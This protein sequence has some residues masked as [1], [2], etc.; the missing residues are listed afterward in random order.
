VAEVIRPFARALYLCDYVIGY[1]NGK[2]DIYGLFN[3]IRASAYPHSQTRFCVF[4]QLTGGLGQVPFFV[5]IL[6][7]PRDEL[8]RTTEVRHLQF[9]DREAVVQLAL[10]IEGC[11]FPD[12]G[13]YLIELYCDNQCV[14]DVPLLLLEG[15]EGDG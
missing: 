6:F 8:V 11:R 4:A 15:D 12:P 1:E 9:S 5:D 14:A 7:R 2:T 13:P 10:E 3:V